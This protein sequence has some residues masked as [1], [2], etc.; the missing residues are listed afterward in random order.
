MGA[1]DTCSKQG[2][3]LKDCGKRIE[4]NLDA[5]VKDNLGKGDPTKARQDFEDKGGNPADFYKRVVDFAKDEAAKEAFKPCSQA[6]VA[7]CAKTGAADAKAFKDKLEKSLTTLGAKEDVDVALDE[8]LACVISDSL[9]GCD[10]TTALCEE[11]AQKNFVAHGGK[12]DDFARKKTQCATR[13]LAAEMGS[14]ATG[15]GVVGEKTTFVADAKN[16]CLKSAKKAFEDG[17]GRSE[18][19]TAKFTQS[20]RAAATEAS[21]LCRA[22]AQ[23]CTK[24]ATSCTAGLDKTCDQLFKDIYAQNGGPGDWEIEMEKGLLETATSKIEVC[25][26]TGGGTKVDRDKCKADAKKLYKDGGGKNDGAFEKLQETSSMAL[27]A[28]QR[29]KCS[30]NTTEC[31]NLVK[32]KLKQMTGRKN[33][34]SA[35]VARA[36]KRG[37]QERLKDVRKGC[38]AVD[39]NST[40]SDCNLLGRIAVEEVLGREVTDAEYELQKRG[41]A[42]SEMDL[43]VASCTG[44]KLAGECKKSAKLKY[45]GVLGTAKSDI[46]F[47]REIERMQYLEVSDE[48]RRCKDE[49][50]AAGDTDVSTKCDARMKSAAAKYTTSG[51]APTNI[52]ALKHQGAVM[53]AIDV[54]QSVGTTGATDVATLIKQEYGKADSNVDFRRAFED[55]EAQVVV[56]ELESCTAKGTSPA[57][58]TKAAKERIKGIRSN[59]KEPIGKVGDGKNEKVQELEVNQAIKK[60][61]ERS[62]VDSKVACMRAG[63]KTAVEC[64]A[65]T[66]GSMQ[67]YGTVEDGD[68]TAAVLE[69]SKR[70]VQQTL[71]T[72][73]PTDKT[74]CEKEAKDSFVEAGNDP[75]AFRRSVRAAARQ[76]A[77]TQYTICASTNAKSNVDCGKDRDAVFTS[78]GMSDASIVEG[79]CDRARAE[80]VADTIKATHDVTALEATTAASARDTARDLLKAIDP[81]ASEDDV[82][83]GVRRAAEVVAARAQDACV[84]ESKL[85][86][87]ATA[88]VAAECST[89]AKTDYLRSGGYSQ[90]FLPALD[91]VLSDVAAETRLACMKVW[92]SEGAAACD[93]EAEAAFTKLAMDPGPSRNVSGTF[94][95]YKTTGAAEAALKHGSACLKSKAFPAGTAIEQTCETQ[96]SDLFVQSGGDIEDYRYALKS[97]LAAEAEESMKMCRRGG[98]STR[99][100]AP[101]TREFFIKEGGEAGDGPS[102]VIQGCIGSHE[103]AVRRCKEEKTRS[104]STENSK[105]ITKADE[106]CLM[107]QSP[108][109]AE[110]GVQLA[111]E[112]L[113]LKQSRM[114]V[115]V[116]RLRFCNHDA[117]KSTELSTKQAALEECKKFAQQDV[118]ELQ[119]TSKDT[120]KEQTEL[121][122]GARRLASQYREECVARADYT[123]TDAGPV[124]S[125]DDDAVKVM[126]E[127]WVGGSSGLTATKAE[128]LTMLDEEAEIVFA[129]CRA[130]QRDINPAGGGTSKTDCAK[131]YKQRRNAGLSGRRL[132]R[133]NA[134]ISQSDIDKAAIDGAHR[135]AKYAAEA[136]DDAGKSDRQIDSA[137]VERVRKSTTY[138]NVKDDVVSALPLQAKTYIV[139]GGLMPVDEAMDTSQKREQAASKLREAKGCVRM[140]RGDCPK[141][142]VPEKIGKDLEYMCCRK[143]NGEAASLKTV[144]KTAKGGK[145]LVAEG[146]NPFTDRQ[147]L[148]PADK[149]NA[150]YS[151]LTLD[152]EATGLLQG[153][154]KVRASRTQMQGASSLNMNSPRATV[155]TDRIECMDQIRPCKVEGSGAF[156]A[157]DLCGDGTLELE[158]TGPQHIHGQVGSGMTVRTTVALKKPMADVS[159]VSRRLSACNEYDGCR[160]QREG[161][162]CSVCDPADLGC[163][164]SA[165]VTTCQNG[166]C[167]GSLGATTK[168]TV[169]GTSAAALAGLHFDRITPDPVVG[170]ALFKAARPQIAGTMIRALD[171]IKF[172][173]P[174]VLPTNWVNIE[175][176]LPEIY[177]FC[178]DAYLYQDPTADQDANGTVVAEETMLAAIEYCTEKAIEDYSNVNPEM[179]A[180]MK[181]AVLDLAHTRQVEHKV[182]IGVHGSMK[183]RPV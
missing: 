76:A 122:R 65:T 91:R 151:S 31:E 108:L 172:P 52:K 165:E 21:R 16:E 150:Y 110:C 130:A 89:K 106:D 140:H 75:E 157:D 3:N 13:R 156:F 175:R 26:S 158:S 138:G 50:E 121:Q 152:G 169:N 62:A 40:A 174:N 99:Q 137:Y 182:D 90:D 70:K 132:K 38:K 23:L 117:E 162:S 167:L 34:D 84:T 176:D 2:G 5:A 114:Q 177:S 25:I 63:G 14:C 35:D 144:K 12:Q 27:L 37:A 160:G 4:S 161:T 61:K 101:K 96:K 142:L 129:E 171:P 66:K 43:V 93:K 36:S 47:E 149:F 107:E 94:E 134:D 11:L 155:K 79:E 54:V 170:E 118:A 125:C 159:T 29:A 124:N 112:Q 109:L 44:G 143:V 56:D 181:K 86:G 153:D 139:Q 45:E 80:L 135:L 82:D 67:Q 51:S 87:K 41:G 141:D 49:L 103:T 105:A 71:E 58:C 8:A 59:S 123:N 46:E 33:V 68:V 183:V 78:S 73:S 30:G 64:L 97:Q 32:D 173:Q 120:V 163:T 28:E 178:R 102:S 83:R 77:C 104:T 145:T 42:R 48:F 55:I 168:I 154:E 136:D 18:D 19:F 133:I 113:S 53:S 6:T 1:K 20:A 39:E 147:Q 180:A 74:A 57:N 85:F 60:A 146:D 127:A 128:I 7:E 15:A 131:Q 126:Q 111:D 22:D 17:G 100:C 92:S 81:S 24:A 10:N 95:A 119:T 166:M 116:E 115:A 179:A 148:Q 98:K 72:C 69:G 9:A 88:L 164:K